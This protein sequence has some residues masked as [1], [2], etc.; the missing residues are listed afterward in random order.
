MLI[1]KELQEKVAGAIKTKLS[2]GG[3]GDVIVSPWEPTEAEKAVRSMIVRQFSDGYV[4]MYKPRNEFNQRSVISRLTVDK[5]N[6]NIYLPNDGEPAPGDVVNGWRSNA[7]RPTIRNKA[8]SIA[9]HATAQLL[10]P[11]VF[12]YNQQSQT[13]DDAAKVMRY[14]LEWSADQCNYASTSFKAVITALFSPAAIVHTEYAEVK[15]Q[16]KRGKKEDGSYEIEEIDD[17]ELSG[18]IDTPVPVDEFYIENAFEPTIQKQGWVIWRR[19]M[20]Y[21]VA[22]TKYKNFKNFQFVAPGMQVIFND[23]NQTFYQ[24]YDSNMR[25]DMVEEVQYWN[26]ELDLYQ[27]VVNGV[28]LTEPDN[29]NPRYDKKYP[30]IHFGFERIDEGRFFYF[31]SLASKL[32]QDADVIDQLYQMIIDGTYLSVMPPMINRGSEV[33]GADVIIPGVTTTLSSAEADLTPIEVA[34]NIGVGKDTMREV[35]EDINMTSV[36]PV[37]EGNAPDKQATAYQISQQQ[38]NAAIVLGTFVHM[39]AEY[40][41]Q[42]GELRMG[43]ILQYMT[44]VDA[45][46]I[47]EEPGLVYRTFFKAP[48]KAGEEGKRI[49]FDASLPL[50]GMLSEQELLDLSFATLDEQGEGEELLKANPE[51]FRNMKFMLKVTP[52]SM[53]PMT[54][55]L[56]RAFRLEIYDRAIANQ[57][58]NQETL[59]KDFLLGAYPELV[60]DPDQYVIEPQPAMMGETS[61]GSGVMPGGMPG[62]P[63]ANMPSAKQLL[64]PTV[65]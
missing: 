34:K 6:F 58:G 24:V 37:S 32:K 47:S 18:F 33:I 41:K 46:K 23:P 56:E 11:K 62:M 59:F 22:E 28:L 55:D 65:R 10:F 17:P 53:R 2:T 64:K 27:I 48:S 57:Y 14:L 54:D 9:G 40:V 63:Q 20:S 50:E 16:V 26:R 44:V 13:Q 42:Y 61:M 15:R 45:A 25:G 51:L 39:I 5:M 21:S 8:M 7:A 12:A 38:K 43:D 1:D 4:T 52:D 35:Q 19:V 30:F 60:S 29:A 36:D 3:S 49:K 31:K